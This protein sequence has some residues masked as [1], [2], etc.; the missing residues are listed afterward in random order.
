MKLF[1]KAG[2]ISVLGLFV[3][4]ATIVSAAGEEDLPARRQDVAKVSK[5]LEKIEK[6]QEELLENQKKIIEELRILKIRIRRGS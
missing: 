2:M 1:L 4:S 6:T 3:L 5:Q